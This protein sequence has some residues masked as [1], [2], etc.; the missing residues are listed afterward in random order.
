[1]ISE[2]YTGRKG[3]GGFYRVNREKGKRK[4]AIDLVSG[5]YREQQ[6]PDIPALN[7]AG[8]SL[9]KLLNHDS[10][11]G[12]FAWNVMGQTLAYA[13]ALVGD[14]SD[15]A[16]SI[17]QAMR[18]GFNWKFGPFELMDQLGTGWF[19][20]RLA[21]SGMAVPGFLKIVAGRPI[22]RI[23]NGLRQVVGLDGAYHAIM[24]PEGVLLLED[25]KRV[26]QPILKNG[27]AALWDVGDGVACFEFISKINSFDTDSLCLIHES[28]QVVKDN[29]KA[30]V[31][32]NDS[33]LFSAG[34]NLRLVTS[35]AKA[36]DWDKIE[37]LIKEGRRAFTAL[38]YAPF[39]VVAAP[40]GM[41][42]G[43]GCE[44]VLAADAVQAH[45]ELNIGLVEVGVGLIPGWGGCKEM[46]QR[47]ATLG[48]LPQGPMPAVMKAF[49]IISAA[50][51]SK[52]AADA[53]EL[54]FMRPDDGVT[55]NRDR[56][57]TD[58]K[59]KALSLVKEYKPPTQMTFNLPG[60]SG[61]VTMELAAQSFHKLGK[62]SD[63]DGVLLGELTKVL[64]GG[65]TDILTPV[66]ENDVLALERKHF[67]HLVHDD[68]SVNRIV[69]M[70]ETGKPLRN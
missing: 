2:G 4:E 13:A 47:W 34:A 38:K 61:C 60:P 45:A 9:T 57:L 1:M 39:P 48:R 40:S 43:G 16:N 35:A 59:T 28:I 26:S 55:K 32:Y 70:L 37:R 50:T 20:E 33:Q 6:K 54:L 36:G 3:I 18:M 14:V 52:S 19:V 21:K 41:A 8:R 51:V 69:H 44:I 64:S 24:C 7:E 56:L 30:L 11:H 10:T 62:A 15:N 22:Y 27:S 53:K 49:E 68:R 58:A 66:T 25:I 46:L 42:L 17:D 63:Y 31:I 23:E 65:D 12:R 67:M 29:F 5:E